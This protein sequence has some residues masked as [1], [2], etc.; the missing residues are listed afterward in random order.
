MLARARRGGRPHPTVALLAEAGILA[1]RLVGAG[2]F[3][4]GDGRWLP[5]GPRSRRG[6]AGQTPGRRGVVRRVV[7]ERGRV[8]GARPG[9]S[10]RRRA[11]ARHAGSADEHVPASARRRARPA[12]T[13]RAA[14]ARGCRPWSRSRCASRPT[15]RSWSR[16]R[17]GWCCRCTTSSNPLHLCDAALLWTGDAGRP[18]L[19]RPGPHPRRHRAAGGRARL[20]G[21][22]P[23]ARAAGARRDHPRHRRARLA[24]ST[25]G[26]A[27]C[28]GCGVDVLWPRSLGRDLTTRAAL[29]HRDERAQE[30]PLMTGLFG[31][32]AMFAFKWQVA[33][34]GEP[35]TDAEMDQLADR[36]Q[37]GAQAA[38]RLD[39]RRPAR[40]PARPASG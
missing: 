33:L 28:G 30:G 26:S 3:E 11:P 12:A 10:R 22:R 2:R 16:A 27:R 23:A 35:L 20:A 39:R 36:G 31:P 24:S 7:T 8:R 40:S 1:L 18:R 6:R 9:R 15:R 38:R 17:S 37:P 32:D 21:A 34:H 4:P 25:T 14:V 13:P 5:L 19:R 29:E